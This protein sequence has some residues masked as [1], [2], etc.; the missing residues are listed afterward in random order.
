M[1]CKQLGVAPSP[2]S[3]DAATTAY[4]DTQ[5]TATLTSAK[6]YTDTGNASTLAS[7]KSYADTGDTSTLTSAESYADTKYSGVLVPVGTA[8]APSSFSGNTTTG[9][10]VSGT[11]TFV[12]FDILGGGT[13]SSVR[14][15]VTTASS[16]GTITHQFGLYY[17]NG[18]RTAP[19]L[20]RGPIATTSGTT[21]VGLKTPALSGGAKTLP[22][23]RYWLSFFYFESAA[24]TTRIAYTAPTN[25]ASLGFLDVTSATTFPTVPRALR[26]TG[27][28]AVA[29]VAPATWSYST[30][31]D[32]PL[33]G[34]FR[35]A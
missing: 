16:G 1:A 4:A 32:F 8:V 7:A 31:A 12:P 20:A 9:S 34:L 6:S 10:P 14:A 27:L 15:N 17:D 13:Y 2:N 24:P 30:A 11:Q 22:A 3:T 26:I 21:T 29:T 18:D 33:I 25:P 35:S 19:D 28:T 5:D 23:G